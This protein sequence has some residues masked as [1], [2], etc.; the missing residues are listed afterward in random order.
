M[1]GRR[2]PSSQVE[3][4]QEMYNRATAAQQANIL[5]HNHQQSFGLDA[6]S[7]EQHHQW[8]PLLIWWFIVIWG[9]K[10][11]GDKILLFP[12]HRLTD[13]QCLSNT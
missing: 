6:A 8:L 5:N 12:Y 10:A 1:G 11:E 9:T 13:T 7:A 3:Q 4:I 2:Q